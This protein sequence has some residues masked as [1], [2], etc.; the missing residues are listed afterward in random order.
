MCRFALVAGAAVA[1]GNDAAGCYCWAAV[2]RDDAS[3]GLR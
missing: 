1:S 3:A 2:Q